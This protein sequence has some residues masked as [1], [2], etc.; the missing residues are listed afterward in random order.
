MTN[1]KTI[2][3]QLTSSH[4][5]AGVVTTADGVVQSVTGH[6]DDTD[7]SSINNNYVEGV[8]GSARVRTP[9]VRQSYLENSHS[10]HL[11]AR[12]SEPFVEVSWDTALDLITEKLKSTINTHGNN[13]IF[14]GSYGWASAGRFHHAQSQLKRFLNCLGGFVRSEGN[15]SY[16]AALVLMP[17]IVGNFR[18]HVKEATR[19]TVVADEAELVVMFGG[20]AIRSAQVG[21]GGLAKHKLRDDLL[22]CADAG[23]EFINLSPLKDDALTALNAT[24][25]APIPGSD[26]AI[27]MGLAHTLIDEN[28]HDQQFLNSHTKGFDKVQSYLLGEQDGII[29]NAEWASRQSGIAA[30]TL[31]SLARRMAA[32]RTLV[33]TAVGLQRA[34]SGEQPLWMTVTLAAMLGQIGKPGCGYG[35]GYGADAAIGTS[36]RPMRWPTLDQGRNPVDDF[37]PV[38]AVA[39][40]LLNPGQLYEYNGEQRTYPNARLMWWVGGNPFH[41]HQDLNRLVA[42]FQTPETIIVNEI[43]WTATARHADIVLPATSALERNDF[44]AGSQDTALIPMPRAIE[45]VGDAMDEYDIYSALAH[46]LDITEKFTANRTTDQWLNHLWTD[47]QTVAANHNVTLPSWSQFLQGDIIEF[48]DPSPQQTFLSDFRSDPEASPLPTA[49]GRIELFSEKIASYN[50]SDCPG[51]ATWLPPEEWLG[52][53][54]AK[55]WPLHLISG[56]PETRLHSQWDSGGFSKSRKIQGREPIL[57]HPENAAQAGIETGDVVR[58]YNDRGAC[59]A[60]AKVTDRVRKDVV[61]LWTGAWYDPH[62]HCESPAEKTAQPLEKHGNPNVLTHDRRSSRLSQGPASHSALVAIEKWTGDL[63]P[64]TAF[65]PP[66]GTKS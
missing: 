2:K 12:G 37:I 27:M 15:Y 47:M 50:Y 41:H 22:A 46:R 53:E 55:R 6:K 64:V 35:I 32:S 65:D 39:D 19:W 54:K 30:D 9:A 60:G 38:A 10:P 49:S 61:F 26:T 48:D 34:E 42:A 17:Y 52:S 18:S 29:K 14:A 7:P 57:I 63:P 11:K 56:Q 59:L 31:R 16:N 3:K 62:L 8:N 40:M 51:Q 43:N 20:V 58:V 21:G 5:G 33:T 23:V 45:P 66:P 13:A 24:W 36:D 44:G 4:W 1:S 28:L 25:I